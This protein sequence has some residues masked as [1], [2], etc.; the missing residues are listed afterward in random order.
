KYIIRDNDGKFGSAFDAIATQ[1]GIDVLR[2]PIKAPKAN[3]ICER[4]IG[5]VRR[6]CLD[7]LLIFGERHLYRVL[8]AYTDYF[9]H[10]RPHQGIN[11]R[12]P[13]PLSSSMNHAQGKIISMPVLNGLHHEYLRAA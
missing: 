7:H 1:S 2:T 9:N 8:K 4:F 10:A 12:V 13:S 3:G 6:E 5:S 11:Q